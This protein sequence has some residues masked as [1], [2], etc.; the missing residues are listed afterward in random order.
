MPESFRVAI[1][2]D[3]LDAPG[4][5]ENVVNEMLRVYPNADVWSLWNLSPAREF[6]NAEVHTTWLAKTPLAGRK[7][8][9]LP[10]MPLVWRNLPR[11]DYDAVITSTVAL[12]HAARFRGN[13]GVTLHYVHTPARYWWTPGVDGR[14]SSIMAAPAR[15][16]LRAL[17]RR[18][19]RKHRHVAANS[20]TTRDRIREFWGIDAEIIYPPVDTDFFTPGPPTSELPFDE[21]VLGVSRWVQYKRLNLVIETA[22]QAGLPVV[23]AGSGPM[24]AQLRELASRVNVPVRFEVRPSRERLRDLYRGANALVFPVH[25]DFGIV[26]VEAIASGTPVVGL[27][28]G[29]LLETVDEGA[30]GRLVKAANPSAL[31]QAVRSVNG[32]SGE[33]LAD[34]A[35]RFSAA[36]FQRNLVRWVDDAVHDGV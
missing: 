8:A 16:G 11:R 33:N 15:A 26:P 3:W 19:A 17:D 20:R 1:V 10:L 23:I 9:A 21:Y 22:A 4:G 18:Y 36:T 32:L 12:S 5:S 13:T 25:E 29:G 35:Q 28:I 30:T 27:A 14:G 31:A 2:H 7:A 6:I 24:E 34:R